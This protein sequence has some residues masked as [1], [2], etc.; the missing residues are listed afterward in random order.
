MKKHEK[1]TKKTENFQTPKNFIKKP[2]QITRN[3]KEER[4]INY[5]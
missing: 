3:K 4:N 1:E 5:K 2:F